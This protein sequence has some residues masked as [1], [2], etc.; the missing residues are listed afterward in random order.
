ME[1]YRGAGNTLKIF[2][3]SAHPELALAVAR[4][5]NISLSPLTITRFPDSE[6]LVRID[7]SVRGKD[8]FIV[9]PTC[10]PVNDNFAELLII[11][12][13]FRRASAGRINIVVPYYGYARQDKKTG[14]REA[15]TAR[16]VADMLI[17]GGADRM[18][19]IDLHSP[20]IQGFFDI[21]VDQLTAMDVLSSYMRSWDLSDAVIV[22]PDAGRVNMATEYANRLG[23]PVVIIH[24][25]RTGAEQTKV[26]YVVGD[27]KGARPIIIDDMIT[28]GGTIDR[29]VQALLQQG[30]LPEV[31]LAI[32]HPVLVGRSLEVL[33]NPAIKR[34]VVSD[35]IALGPEKQMEKL[36][37][38]SIAPL[39]AKAIQHIHENNSVSELFDITS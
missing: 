9:Q 32:T 2:S 15:I 7:A 31:C 20:Q 26:V 5:L 24:K 28:T 22:A 1:S 39:I 36:K 11:L 12:D 19:T 33:S 23:V 38:I 10:P 27:V 13:A 3:G 35:T 16:M 14:G 34:V 18:L 21:P 30:A 29:S 4:H 6:L 8:V 25:R 17:R 37:V